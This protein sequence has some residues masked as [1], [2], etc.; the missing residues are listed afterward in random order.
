MS[1]PRIQPL[2]EVLNT[3]PRLLGEGVSDDFLG[4]DEA[5]FVVVASGA[6][7]GRW[8]ERGELIVCEA[9]ARPGQAIV[10]VA[11]SH[12]RPRLGL[13]VGF[14]Y[15]GDH[16]EPCSAGRW[17]AAGHIRAVYR[18]SA[19]GDAASAGGPQGW[20]SV[21]IALDRV[22]VPVALM[23]VGASERAQRWPTRGGAG[24]PPHSPV[25]PVQL[26]LFAA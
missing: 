22:G 4:E 21:D 23:E 13:R 18:R 7:R 15:L 10:L 14:G 25:Q 2:H 3:H 20:E 26:A 19:D 12:G 5:A 16:E 11:H 9:G 6:F 1:A 8:F 17:M 24:R